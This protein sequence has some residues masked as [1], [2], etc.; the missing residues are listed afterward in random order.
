MLSVCSPQM[1]G[2]STTVGSKSANPLQNGVLAKQNTEFSMQTVGAQV[3][4]RR[5]RPELTAYCCQFPWGSSSGSP[6]LLMNLFTTP[7]IKLQVLAK[8]H[9]IVYPNIEYLR[10][11][12]LFPFQAVNANGTQDSSRLSGFSFFFAEGWG[13]CYR[14]WRRLIHCINLELIAWTYLAIIQ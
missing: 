5:Q 9:H 6:I 4:A 12:S 7:R 8:Q 1:T 14:S 3:S 10:T 13:D 2:I 11:L